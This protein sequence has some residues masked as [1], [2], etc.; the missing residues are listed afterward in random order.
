MAMNDVNMV[1]VGDTF[2]G[3]PDPDDV[4]KPVKHLI[5]GADIAFCNLET[6]V[7]DSNHIDQYDRDQ[8]PRMDES[9]IAAYM[10][11]GFN[12]MNQANNPHTYHG[13]HALV[14]SVEVLE[15]MNVA[16]GGQA[17]ILRKRESLPS[18]SE[19]VLR[20]LL[21][22]GHPSERLKWRRQL[23]RQ[24]WPVT[25][26]TRSTKPLPEYIQ[27]PVC[28]HLSIRFPTVACIVNNSRKIFGMHEMQQMW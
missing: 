5:Q 14:R 12:F 10:R 23:I 24:E 19:T 28:C 1:L 8:R 9:S 16:H 21:F 20:L 22:V 7:A 15:A 11:A 13:L 18:S 2:V 6:V 4:F 26:S 27:I 17:G 25:R 3:R